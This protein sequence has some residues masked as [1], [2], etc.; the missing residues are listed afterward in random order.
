[1][2]R[3][4]RGQVAYWLRRRRARATRFGSD[5][6]RGAKLLPQIRHWLRTGFVATGKIINLHRA[7][8]SA[9]NVASLA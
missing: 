1:L 9:K 3:R 8:H 7:G 2:F 6:G 4:P 5:R